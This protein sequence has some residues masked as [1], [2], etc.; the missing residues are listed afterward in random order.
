[1]STL[2]EDH[3]Y[4]V[5]LRRWQEVSTAI[6]HLKDEEKA[7]RESLFQGSFPSPKEGVNTIELPTGEVLK[8]THRITRK[9]D[10][11]LYKEN[12]TKIVKEAAIPSPIAQSLIKTK[13]DLRVG[14]FKK[15]DE[16]QQKLVG[17][18]LIIKPGLPSLE[19]VP[20]KTNA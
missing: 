6:A 2:L 18:V 12:W 11:K 3:P 20:A 5:Q 13:Y 19:L 16:E 4:F 17:N 15:L 10:E 8:G 9:I 1:M 14:P 7:L